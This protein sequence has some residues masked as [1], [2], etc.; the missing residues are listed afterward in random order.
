MLSY[1]HLNLLLAH[2]NNKDFK[3]FWETG[4][5]LKLK[6]KSTEQ[7]QAEIYWANIDKSIC[8]ILNI[9]SEE[10]TKIKQLEIKKTKEIGQE[11]IEYWQSKIKE[12]KNLSKEEAISRLIKSEKIETKIKTIMKAISFENQYE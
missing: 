6:L 8:E 10:L 3:L 12:Y 1:T 11:G 2:N 5:N 9:N 7:Q 4:R